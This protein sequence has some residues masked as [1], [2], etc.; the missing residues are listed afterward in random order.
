MRPINIIAIDCGAS[1]LKAALFREG[2]I[3]RESSC[4]APEV[5]KE[6]DIFTPCQITALV[7]RVREVLTEL[8]EGLSEAVVCISNEMHGFILAHEDGS[9]FMDYIS[10]QKE[11][12]A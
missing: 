12:Q 4:K 6:E 9:P 11:Y 1:F 7:S 10:W 3:V 2:H 8:S 5:H